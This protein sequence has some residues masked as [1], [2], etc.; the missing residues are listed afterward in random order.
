MSFLLSFIFSLQQNQRTGG[1][2]RFCPEAREGEGGPNN[3][4]KCENAK[5]K[6]KSL[7]KGIFI[8]NT[9]L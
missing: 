3:V 6:K 2:N 7:K 5:K 9:T 4:S 8:R 1:Q